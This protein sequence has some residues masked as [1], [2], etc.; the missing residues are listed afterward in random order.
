MKY[1]GFKFNKIVAEKFKEPSGEISVNSNFKMEEVNKET[2]FQDQKKPVFGFVFTY[3]L[4]YSDIASLSFDGI[5]YLEIED[6]SLIKELEKTKK[7]SNKELQEFIMN[8]V[9]A[10]IHVES[11]HLEEKLNLP[12]H[13]RAP[14]VNIENK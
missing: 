13:I 7:V 11:L 6:K 4:K 12:F 8:V 3:D 2:F 9:L 14:R 10:K 1:V 5:V